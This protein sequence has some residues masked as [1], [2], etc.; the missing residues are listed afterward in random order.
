MDL[1][2]VLSVRSHIHVYLLHPP[3]FTLCAGLSVTFTLGFYLMYRKECVRGALGYTP[4]LRA[5]MGKVRIFIGTLQLNATI[6]LNHRG[7]TPQSLPNTSGS[8]ILILIDFNKCNMNIFN[9]IDFCPH[10]FERHFCI[11]NMLFY[12]S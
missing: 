9:K 1:N 12:C 11:Q 2:F 8:K 3:V 7:Q 4:P 10:L 6:Y 5:R